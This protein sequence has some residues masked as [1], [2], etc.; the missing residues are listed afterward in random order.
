MRRQAAA[1]T[2]A[3]AFS[4]TCG[5]RCAA[6]T[7]PA[8]VGRWRQ[9]GLPLLLELLGGVRAV[10]G[11]GGGGERAYAQGLFCQA[12][13][14]LQVCNVLN[15]EYAQVRCRGSCCAVRVCRL[16]RGCVPDLLATPEDVAPSA[17]QA[18]G[19]CNDSGCRSA[20]VR[21]FCLRTPGIPSS[22][23]AE[24]APALLRRPLAMLPSL[25]SK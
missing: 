1:P 7:L 16:G 17:C 20:C 18:P 9:L 5:S 4:K 8:A 14:C 21:H 15:E 10:A 11:G 2:Q 13:A 3:A 6:E 23:L 25:S 12:Q 22:M 24:S 19:P